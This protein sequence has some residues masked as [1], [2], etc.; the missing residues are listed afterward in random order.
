MIYSPASGQTEWNDWWMPDCSLMMIGMIGCSCGLFGISDICLKFCVLEIGI[1][2]RIF[3]SWFL[4]YL[5][6]LRIWAIIRKYPKF[7]RELFVSKNTLHFKITFHLKI[8][9][10]ADASVFLTTT[11]LSTIY[12]QRNLLEFSRIYLRKARSHDLRVSHSISYLLFHALNYT[13]L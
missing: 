11:L 9:K 4:F 10:I 6:L 2:F 13:I 8:L 7:N 5:K 12:V 3:A 1:G